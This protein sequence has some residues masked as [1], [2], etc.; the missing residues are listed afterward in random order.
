MIERKR[1][2]VLIVDDSELI[3]RL[4]TSILSAD[5]MLTVVGA[6]KDAY[7]AKDMVKELSPDVITLDIEMPEV[8]GLRFLQVL[9]KA[10][11]IPVVMV[12]TLTEAHATATLQAL[13]YGA[14]DYMPKPKMY[15]S[16]TLEDYGERIVKKVRMAAG[17]NIRAIRARPMPVR[18]TYNKQAPNRVLAIGASTGGTEAIYNLLQQLPPEHFGIIISQHMPA[19]FTKTYAERL[20]RQTGFQVLE[21]VGGEKIQPGVAY[22][23]PG[24]YHLTLR[25]DGHILY[26]QIESSEKVSGHRPSVDVMFESVANVVGK[27]AIAVLLTGMGKDGARGLKSIRDQG[28]YT[29]AQDENSCVVFGMPREA[30]HIGAACSVQPLSEMGKHLVTVV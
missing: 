4:L 19:G 29:V 30:I 24:D 25:R 28:G 14:V 23:A 22:L 2:K 17:S 13:E 12:S 9:M 16:G 11:P 21:A 3:R 27:T 6:A 15:D 10:N 1:I 5:P 7:E 26:T 18:A 20:N 8:N